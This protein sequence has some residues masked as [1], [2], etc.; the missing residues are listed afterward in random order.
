MNS[1]IDGADRTK[2]MKLKETV[3]NHIYNYQ[4]L[5][6]AFAIFFLFSGVGFTVKPNGVNWFWEG[7]PVIALLVAGLSLLLAFVWIKIEKH[8]I[9]KTIESIQ[10]VS[11]NTDKVDM[12]TNRQK[13]VFDLILQNKSNK[14]ISEEL[15]I[16]MST[17]KT[18]INK[19]YKTLNVGS[20][21][22]VRSF[23]K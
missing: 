15:F 1:K 17:L 20:R 21:K 19:I 7:Y 12:L 2:Q 11:D 14:E 16:E 8:K 23:K 18:H 6:L 9:N 13:Q 22:E 10:H 4:K 5:V 3:L